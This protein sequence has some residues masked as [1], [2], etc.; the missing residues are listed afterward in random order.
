MLKGEE[1][2]GSVTT[3]LQHVLLKFFRIAAR[4]RKVIIY[5]CF[6]LI[7]VFL[8]LP[9]WLVQMCIMAGCDF[10]PNLPGIG[11]KKAHGHLKK[12]RNFVKAR[13]IYTITCTYGTTSYV[14]IWYIQGTVKARNEYK[15]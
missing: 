7:T 15:F 9:L 8:V 13:H 6:L 2:V 1:R 5:W 14:G 12:L 4:K 3:L 10:L 11:V